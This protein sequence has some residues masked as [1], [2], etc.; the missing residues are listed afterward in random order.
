MP[1]LE[2]K[3]STGP[4]L[5]SARS[6]RRRRP[7]RCRGR[8]RSRGRRSRPRPRR[9]PRRRGRRRRRRGRRRRRRRA[10]RR[11]RSRGAAGDDDMGAI[12]L[13]KAEASGSD[14]TSGRGIYAGFRGFLQGDL[15]LVGAA[16]GRGG[17]V[18]APLLGGPR[19]AGGGDPG[20]RQ[21]HPDPNRRGARRRAA[22][23]LPRWPRPFREQGGAGGGDG[24][25]QWEALRADAAE[26]HE[27]FG[28]TLAN[29]LGTPQPVE[30]S[31]ES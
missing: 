31:A 8:P 15:L 17:G 20:H 18:R 10:P 6:I 22:L 7:A 29:G 11:R 9:P 1:A 2:Q 21:P 12:D 5:A 26:M 4:Y 30:L 28:V 19:A 3:T 27:R 13:H 24:T 25:P 23:L 14:R 16:P